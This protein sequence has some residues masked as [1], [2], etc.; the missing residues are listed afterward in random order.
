MGHREDRRDR[1]EDRSGTMVTV[2]I[3]T[4]ETEIGT[5]SVE[6]RRERGSETLLSKEDQERD[7]SPESS[8]EKSV[9]WYVH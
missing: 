7:R 6:D 8:T 4:R 9:Y 3:L 5:G 2:R 1:T